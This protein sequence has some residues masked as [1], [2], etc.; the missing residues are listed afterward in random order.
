MRVDVRDLKDDRQ[1]CVVVAEGGFFAV[2][3]GVQLFYSNAVHP[4]RFAMSEG[5]GRGRESLLLFCFCST[6][7][8]T[9]MI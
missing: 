5:I 9:N 7:S 4:M 2:M 6:L 1:E 8:K 3:V